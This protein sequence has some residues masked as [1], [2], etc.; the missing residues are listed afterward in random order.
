MK[1]LQ[2]KMHNWLEE[3]TKN[4]DENIGG[5]Q[6]LCGTDWVTERESIFFANTTKE[7][8]IPAL[9]VIEEKKQQ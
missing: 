5:E 7:G 3:W 6:C 9:S 1:T 4:T 2:N 8:T